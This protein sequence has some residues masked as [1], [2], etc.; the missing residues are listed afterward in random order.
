MA[1]APLVG[2]DGGSYGF[3]LPDGSTGI[4]LREGL[5][6]FWLICPSGCFVAGTTDMYSLRVQATQGLKRGS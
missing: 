2:Q 5:D 6:R 3:D 4:F 1:D